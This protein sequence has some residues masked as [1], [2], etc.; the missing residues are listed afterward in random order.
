L[1]FTLLTCIFGVLAGKNMQKPRGPLNEFHLVM[2][3]FKSTVNDTIQQ[4]VMDTYLS[5]YNKCVLP[6]GKQ[7]I[8]LMTGGYNNSMEAHDQGFTQ[9][10]TVVFSS[11]QDRDYFVGRPYTTP[12]DPLHDAFKAYVGPLLDCG[13]SVNCNQ[14]VFVFDY[15]AV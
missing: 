13:N 15:S 7:Y 6:N 2:F 1:A 12:Y 14:G 8:N 4:Q 9:G 11:V 10:Y 5:L 3:K